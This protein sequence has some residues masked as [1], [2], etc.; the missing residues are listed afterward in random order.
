MLTLKILNSRVTYNHDTVEVKE[1][2]PNSEASMKIY[3]DTIERLS[4][5][6]PHYKITGKNVYLPS[7]EI[8][9]ADVKSFIY[10]AIRNVIR[11]DRNPI[12]SVSSE[13]VVYDFSIEDREVKV[14]E[15]TP[16]GIHILAS[17]LQKPLLN[18]P[19]NLPL[20]AWVIPFK[21]LSAVIS[22][23]EKPKDVLKKHFQQITRIE[24]D[25]GY[26]EKTGLRLVKFYFE[27]ARKIL[28]Y[29]QPLGYLCFEDTGTVKEVR[30]SDKEAESVI[31]D[32]IYGYGKCVVE[33]GMM[34]I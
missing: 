14:V 13:G 22:L 16:N 34:I 28:C 17:V 29:T 6:T 25:N 31:N 8:N 32:I 18:A 27:G 3:G 4:L 24:T 33:K 1:N 26:V 5:E 11:E 7:K 20:P 19:T 12:I 10:S 21:L 30:I 9:L 2:I 15:K 23:D